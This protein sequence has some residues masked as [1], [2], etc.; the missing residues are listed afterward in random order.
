MRRQPLS[1]CLRC[2]AAKLYMHSSTNRDYHTA[3]WTEKQRGGEEWTERGGSCREEKKSNILNNTFACTA[4]QRI[5][6]E[7]TQESSNQV[8]LFMVVCAFFGSEHKIYHERRWCEN[9]HTLFTLI[10][11]ISNLSSTVE[12]IHSDTAAISCLATKSLK[13]FLPVIRDVT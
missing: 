5:H 6:V 12:L 8:F 10:T 9:K 13:C 11:A 3:R 1:P 2:K 4:N 7:E